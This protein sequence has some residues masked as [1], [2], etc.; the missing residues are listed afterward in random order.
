MA[1]LNILLST[2][3]MCLGQVRTLEEADQTSVEW[4]LLHHV[5]TWSLVAF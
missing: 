4:S 3:E 5:P 1:W 2:V